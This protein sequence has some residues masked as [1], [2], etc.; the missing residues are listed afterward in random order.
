M[1]WKIEIKPTAEKYFLKLDK[2]TRKRIKEA[3]Q[4]LEKSANPLLHQNVR[5]LTGQLRGDYRLRVGDW[6]ILF[7]PDKNLK[8]LYVYAILP[9]GEAYKG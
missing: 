9:R 5:S 8:I 7:T 1:P 3:L 2:R 6:R 4:E